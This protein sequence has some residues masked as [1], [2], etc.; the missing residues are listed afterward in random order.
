MNTLEKFPGA[1]T[2]WVYNL[3]TCMSPYISY[4]HVLDI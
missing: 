3:I 4:L 2:A 1:A